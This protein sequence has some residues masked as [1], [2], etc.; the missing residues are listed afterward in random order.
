MTP[1]FYAHRDPIKGETTV[2]IPD[3]AFHREGCRDINPMGGLPRVPVEAAIAQAYQLNPQATIDHYRAIKRKNY[4][5]R[6]PWL[7]M[8]P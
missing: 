4:L 7:R 6:F 8:K 2:I 1:A 3:A 5:R